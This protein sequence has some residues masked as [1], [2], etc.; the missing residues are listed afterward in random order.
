MC[1]SASSSVSSRSPCS[2]SHSIVCRT[3]QGLIQLPAAARRPA[4]EHQKRP[5]CAEGTP[6]RPP[7]ARRHTTV[8]CRIPFYSALSCAACAPR[9]AGPRLRP[10]QVS[11]TGGAAPRETPAFYMIMSACVPLTQVRFW[12]PI[13]IRSRP[14]ARGP[15]TPMTRPPTPVPR[16]PRPNAPTL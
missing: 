2:P 9:Q 7:T 10:V 8:R 11:C 5:R 4:L 6:Q 13:T 1:W 12:A 16:G 14:N 3:Q 15:P